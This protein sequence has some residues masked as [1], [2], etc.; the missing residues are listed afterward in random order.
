MLEE[1]KQA[2]GALA[3]L[4]SGKAGLLLGMLVGIAVLIFGFWKTVFVLL[5]GCIGHYVALRMEREEDWLK[6]VLAS[7]QNRLP[8]KFQS[9]F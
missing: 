9:W 8:D 3:E 1:L 2:V 4:C 6:K 7:I 5:C